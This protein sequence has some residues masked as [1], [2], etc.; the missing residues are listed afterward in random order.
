MGDFSHVNRYWTNF[1]LQK[2][3]VSPFKMCKYWRY[4]ANFAFRALF[5]ENE[6]RNYWKWN[7]INRI[8][9]NWNWIFWELKVWWLIRSREKSRCTV[10]LFSAVTPTIHH[11]FPLPKKLGI[12]RRRSKCAQCSC[13]HFLRDF[14]SRQLQKD[15]Q[16]A[17]N[18][19]SQNF[20]SFMFI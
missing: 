14:F 12:R 3:Q 7:W 19:L 9:L 15:S 10:N 20:S 1:K 8:K 6:A 13:T 2:S 5:L 11:I 16:V 18:R 4:A 17:K